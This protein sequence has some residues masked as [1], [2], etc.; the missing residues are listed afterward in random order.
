MGMFNYGC[1][2]LVRGL[3]DENN[4]II[5]E[6]I[7]MPPAIKRDQS[8]SIFSIDFFSGKPNQGVADLDCEWSVN[9]L[10]IH[11][12]IGNISRPGKKRTMRQLL[13]CQ[14]FGLI[15]LR[16]VAE[17]ILIQCIDICKI[18]RHAKRILV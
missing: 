11:I 9:V 12:Q 2:V 15:N 5:V 8:D 10:L 14:R 18:T 4:V 3:F 17:G 1:F 13:S 6:N 7:S 16:L